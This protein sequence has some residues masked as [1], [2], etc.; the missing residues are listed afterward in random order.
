MALTRLKPTGVNNSASFTLANLTVSGNTTASYFVGNGSQLTSI[1]T[2]STV[3]TAAQPN[4]TSVGTLSSVSVTGN[5]SSGNANLGNLITS[6]YYAGV[7]TTGA[8]PN[9]TSTGNLVS[10]IV[11]GTS[12]FFSTQDVTITGTPSGT[13][14]YDIYNG[15][16]FDVTPTANWTA[17]VSNVPAANNRTTVLTFIIT[18]GG[19]P[20]VPN[21]F[22]ISG[23]SQS[24]K[25]L[26]GSAPTGTA[27]KTDV[28]SFSIVKSSTGTYTVLGQSASYG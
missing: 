27:S 26:N 17:N 8:Q 23:T 4:I 6:N 25:W 5:I 24:V 15:V 12:T 9:I 10:L 14:N 19:T 21:V 28:I 2:A 3:T 16:V 11:T 13:V 20:Y 18:Q 22:Q 1:A 7:L